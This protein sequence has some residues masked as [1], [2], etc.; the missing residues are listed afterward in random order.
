MC[1]DKVTPSVPASPSS[2]SI[3]TSSRSAAPER[4]GQAPLLPLHQHGD[5]K[6]ADLH[7]NPLPFSEQ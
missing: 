3:S 4:T 2:L 5:D 1:F 7:D 6:D